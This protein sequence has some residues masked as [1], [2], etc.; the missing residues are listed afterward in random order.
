MRTVLWWLT[1]GIALVTATQNPRASAETAVPETPIQ[2]VIVIV[3]ENRT[4]DHVF[5]GYVPKAG[6]TISNLLSKGIIN[7]DGSP[8]PSFALAGQYKAQNTERYSISPDKSGP[9]PAVDRPYTTGALGLPPR[10]GDERFP[11]RLPNGPYQIS[12]YVPYAGGFTGDPVHRFFQMWQQYDGGKADLLQWVA[13][14]VGTG[15]QNLHPATPEDTFQGGMAMG[16][17]N[18]SAGDAPVF[19]LMADNYAISDN[20]H[21]GIMGGTGP[22]FFYLGTGDVAFFTDGAG[23]PLKPFDAQIE[24]PDPKSG[25]NNFY[26]RDGYNGGSYVNCSDAAQPG[27]AAIL[28]YLKSLPYQP[29]RGGNCAPGAYYLVNNYEAGYKP[30][31]T[32]NPPRSAGDFRLTPQTVP[33]IA[34]LLSAHG[35]SW[36]YYIGGWKGGR[37]DSNWCS[38]CNPMASSKSV[39]TTSL[40]SNIKDVPD[41]Y[42]DVAA[43]RLPA[44]SFLRPYEF[45]SG[46]PA[47]S[48]LSVYEDFVSA[49]VNAVILNRKLFA[50]SA[51]FVTLDEGG[52]Y[53]DSGYIQPIDF[54][55]D[56]PRIP[57]I[58]VSPYVK[59]GSVD[60]SYADHGSI[61]KF[62]EANWKLPPLSPRSRDNLP[63]PVPSRADPYVP[64][65]APALSDL[66]SAFD[67]AHLRDERHA[68]AI[69][70][71]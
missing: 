63:N 43:G 58:I 42:A 54:F 36:K 25:T 14:T 62:I 9:Y 31:G 22:N 50:T 51:I 52:G 66:M 7:P 44:V 35:I 15:P 48:T 12:R 24:N 32:P 39:M 27:V 16:F 28:N 65:N 70:V 33:T 29:F 34:D 40:R 10:V 30:D 68:P 13:E 60:H 20:Y 71:R 45:Y 56:G 61:L 46:H 26:T 37:P 4:F 49:A 17:Y 69:A 59:A 21:Q 41:F 19:K 3:G 11:A 1:L 23:H 67:F 38:I 64:A 18:M 5:G 55:G 8:G 53:Y 47:D 6:Q 2:H 57:L